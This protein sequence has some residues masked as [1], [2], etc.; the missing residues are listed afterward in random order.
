MIEY[1]CS[2]RGRLGCRRC[3][4]TGWL[5]VGTSPWRIL[6]GALVG[7]LAGAV[8]IFALSALG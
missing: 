1:P 4:G 5:V 2:C 8:V 7:L 3:M 6:A